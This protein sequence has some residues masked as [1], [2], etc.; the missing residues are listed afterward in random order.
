[1]LNAFEKIVLALDLLV[2]RDEMSKNNILNGYT[3]C[4][5]C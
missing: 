3:V 5:Y 2:T 1:M 4:D